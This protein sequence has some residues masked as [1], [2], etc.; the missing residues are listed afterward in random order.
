[1]TNSTNKPT[2]TFWIISIT[3]LL[4]NIM[5]VSAYLG[6][7][8]MT[9]EVL[10]ALPNAEQAYYTNL[11]AWVTAAFAISVFSGTLGCIIMLLRK[12]LAIALFIISLVTVLLQFVYNFILQ[13][14]MEISIANFIM[15]IVV[16]IIASFL[17]WYS[18]KSAENNWIF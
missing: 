8:Y 1:M 7:A 13:K 11:P 9:N 14:E 5:G 3:A 2:S 18:K 12:K 10:V 16:I 4:W 6:Q 15:P 17:V